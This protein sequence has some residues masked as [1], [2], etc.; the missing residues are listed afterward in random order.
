MRGESCTDLRLRLM[1]KLAMSHIGSFLVFVKISNPANLPNARYVVICI[2][3][4][5]IFEK[6][7]PSVCC[8]C[9]NNIFTT[10]SI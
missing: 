1:C 7:T 3:E 8:I 5:S 10:L 4:Y 6:T 9:S 2:F